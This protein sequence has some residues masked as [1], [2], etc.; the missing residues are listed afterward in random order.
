[1]L[2]LVSLYGG[3]AAANLN[4]F[5]QY[6][7]AWLVRRCVCGAGGCVAGGRWASRCMWVANGA[8]G[9]SGPC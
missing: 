5:P 1:M 4:R 6:G 2:V 8:C 3:F 9:A 7:Y